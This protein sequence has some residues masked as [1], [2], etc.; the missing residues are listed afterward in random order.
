MLL[1]LK[2]AK[3]KTKNKQTKKHNKSKKQ[4]QNKSKQQQHIIAPI[5]VPG[6]ECYQEI[7]L[8]DQ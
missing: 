8:N 6:E 7:A 2:K 5:C 1:S 4:Q 3:T